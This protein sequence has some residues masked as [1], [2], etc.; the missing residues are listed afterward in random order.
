MSHSGDSPEPHPCGD[1]AS[2]R[3]SLVLLAGDRA[4]PEADAALEALCRAYWYPI[5]AYIRR[6][7]GSADGAEELTQEFFT[8]LLEKNYLGDV[9]RSRGRFRRFLL[10]CCKH[11]LANERDRARAQ[12]RGGGRAILSLDFAGA[13]ER[14]RLEPADALTAEKLFERRWAL[15]LIDQVLDQLLGE[16]CTEGKGPLYEKLK[17]ALVG[18][19]DALSY[20]A[21]GAE[22]GMSEAAVKKAAERLRRR[23]REIF[24]ARIAAT[25]EGPEDIEDE[26]RALFAIL[27]S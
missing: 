7:V 4:A 26:I 27:S 12:K 9:E 14:Y 8:R 17:L 25:V 2:T 11:F 24:R 16:S 21:I 20:A 22:L 19:S 13:V 18:A 3:W 5:Y 6:H 10:A 1:F 23:Y 15:T